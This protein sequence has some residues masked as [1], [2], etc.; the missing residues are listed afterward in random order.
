MWVFRACWGQLADV[1]WGACGDLGKGRLGWGGGQGC[2]SWTCCGLS[3]G[4]GLR[5]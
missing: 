1:R 3:L 4:A 2:A 5:V